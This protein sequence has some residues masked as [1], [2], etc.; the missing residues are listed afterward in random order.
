MHYSMEQSREYRSKPVYMANWS[1]T[2]EPSIHNGER[3]FFKLMVGKLNVL[4]VKLLQS[5]LTHCNSMDCR[6]P[7]SSVH[8][9]FPGKNPGVGCHAIL[10]GIFS[11]QGSNPGLPHSR[12]IL[13][14]LSHQR[15]PWKLDIQGQ[16]N[17]IEF[18]FYIQI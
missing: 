5:C 7:G 11:T 4:Y 6:P 12:W 3:Q 16:N 15:S 17:N 9:D 18:L 14:C 2:R 8:E 10:Q 1:L 13:Y